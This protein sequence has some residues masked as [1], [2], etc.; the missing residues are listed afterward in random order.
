M[1]FPNIISIDFMFSY[2]N[3][4]ILEVEFVI[5]IFLLAEKIFAVARVMVTCVDA[6]T[7]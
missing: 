4:D 5:C 6:S 1:V 7:E 2:L 3:G